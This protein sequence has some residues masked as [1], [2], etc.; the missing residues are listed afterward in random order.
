MSTNLQPTNNNK[1]KIKLKTILIILS[2]FIIIVALAV[3][4]IYLWQ[5]YTNTEQVKSELKTIATTM[6]KSRQQGNGYPNT[7]PANNNKAVFSGGS[8]SDG[9]IYCI[10]ATSTKDKS[11]VYHIDSTKAAEGPL[12]GSCETNADSSAPS[13]PG[14]LAFTTATSSELNVRWDSAP[15]ATSYG[16]QCST[17]EK[18]SNPTT[19]KATNTTGKFEKL[20][21]STRY[22]CRVKATNS[23]GDS[24]WS[25]LITMDTFAK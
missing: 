10:S 25:S 1:P 5:K 2:M 3:T 14:G 20:K 15:H 9:T 17:D 7:I 8:S 24:A 6:D 12:V 4:G 18:F 16:L 23:I 22:F 19:V 21:S 13:T 11:I